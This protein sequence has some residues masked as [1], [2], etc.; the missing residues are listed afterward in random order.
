L[1]GFLGPPLAGI[2]AAI[3]IVT[4]FLAG[5]EPTLPIYGWNQ[6][7][8]G[9]TPLV[10]AIFSLIGAASVALILIAMVVIG[11]DQDKVIS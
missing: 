5:I 7:R 3:D 6:M 10:N 4:L 1:A 8:F 9:F 2:C 11:P